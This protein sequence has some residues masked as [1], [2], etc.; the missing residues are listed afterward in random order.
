MPRLEQF[1][2]S[3][4]PSPGRPVFGAARAL[5]F[6]SSKH[7]GNSVATSGPLARL[8]QPARQVSRLPSALGSIKVYLNDTIGN[9]RL[10]ALSG[11]DECF[12][13]IL[14]KEFVGKDRPRV[15]A[16]L[17]TAHWFARGRTTKKARK[18]WTSVAAGAIMNAAPARHGGNSFAHDRSCEASMD[19]RKSIAD[20]YALDYYRSTLSTRRW[21]S[22]WNYAA[23][24][25]AVLLIATTYLIA[26]NAM[27]QAAPVSSV[28]SSFGANCGSCHTGNDV[29]SG[30][31]RLVH[32]AGGVPSVSN[33]TCNECHHAAT[34]ATV[35]FKEPNCTTCHQEH[36]PDT[37]LVAVPDVACTGCHANLKS[38]MQKENVAIGFA[39]NIRQFEAGDGGHPE[40]AILRD[41][42]DDVSERHAALRLATFIPNKE[43]GGHWIDRG[44]LTKFNHQLHLDPK[45]SLGLDRKPVTKQC[46]DCHVTDADGSMRPIVYEAHCREC[47]PLTL[48]SLE[49]GKQDL[50][51]STVE[52]VL[53]VIRERF[54]RQIAD[55]ANAL[56]KKSENAANV[57]RLPALTRLSDIQDQDLQERMNGAVHEMLGPEAKGACRHCHRL[58][59]HD[60]EWHVVNRL[61][62]SP[63]A[64]VA[65]NQPPAEMVPSRWLPHAKFNHTSHRAV[66][67][68][69]CHKAHESTETATILMPSIAVCR[70]C[71]GGDARSSSTQVSADCVLCHTYHNGMHAK[72]FHGTSLETL[73]PAASIK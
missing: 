69:A 13:Q 50:P 48:A 5:V 66:A 30:G 57:P 3:D 71:H 70:E 54:A 53:G 16:T 58:E 43:G 72:P 21:K 20:K 68:V 61:G 28:H 6:A 46:V 65:A 18:S 23:L 51:H 12:W 19:Q 56:A 17:V 35:E 60:R 34:H 45:Q 14:I 7:G 27:F 42:K 26:R 2:R 38:A 33:Q 36:R 62:D 67:C 31:R 63:N 40:F 44:G 11:R 25:I 52:E 73:F 10:T 39:P 64:S 4:L 15:G 47:H 55:G 37:S 8:F 1:G 9:F 22:P 59:Q 49:E 24:V 29:W 32:P 41:N